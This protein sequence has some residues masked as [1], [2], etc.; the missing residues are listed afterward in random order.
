LT[1][2]GPDDFTRRLTTAATAVGADK[3]SLAATLAQSDLSDSEIHAV[4]G[5]TNALQIATARRLAG[6]SGARVV[7]LSAQEKNGQ[8]AIGDP[9]E[10]PS[11]HEDDSRNWFE[12]ATDAVAGA[13]SNTGNFLIHNPVSDKIFEGLDFLGNVAHLPFRLLS[14]A[15]DT[16]N[17]DEIDAQMKARGYDPNSTASYLAFMF[18]QGESQYHDLSHV[19]DVYGD[20]DVELA[21]QILDDPEQFYSDLQKRGDAE[22]LTKKINSKEFQ[23]VLDAVDRRHISPGRDLARLLTVEETKDN[24]GGF[25]TEGG[26]LFTALSGTLD[27]AYDWFTDPTLIIGKGARVARA[28][29]AVT[30]AT[31]ASRLRP[32]TWA[33]RGWD[34][35]RGGKQRAGLARGTDTLVDQSGVEALLRTDDSGRAVTTVG[36]GWQRYLEDNKAWRAARE[37]GDEAK[38][39]GIWAE[40]NARYGPMMSLWDEVGGARVIADAGEESGYRVERLTDSAL[41]TNGTPIEDLKTLRDHLVSTNGLVRIT[42]GWAAKKNLVMP[43]RLSMWAE[44]RAAAGTHRAKE[45]ERWANY[46]DHR[47]IPDDREQA[48]LDRYGDSEAARAGLAQARLMD[49]SALVSLRALRAKGERVYRRLA[50]QIPNVDRINLGDTS[51]PKVV[52]QLARTYMN[53]GDAARVASAYQAGTI[54][55]R[56]TILRGTIEQAFHASGLS[57]S[58]AGRNF[59]QRFLNDQD[60]VGN[61]LYGFGKTSAFETEGRG[62]IQAAL[63]PDQISRHVILPSFRE[64]NYLATKTAM[65]G[66]VGRRG[67]GHVRAIGQSEGMDALMG[68]IKMG[69]I[70]S[71]AGGLRNAIDEIA[72]FAAYGMLGQVAAARVAYTKA[73]EGLRQ[74]K[75]EAAR[76]RLDLIQ[77]WGRKEADDRISRKLGETGVSLDEANRAAEKARNAQ[78]ALDDV[79][80]KLHQRVTDAHTGRAEAYTYRYRALQELEDAKAAGLPEDQ[81]SV[82]RDRATYWSDE[83]SK[84]EATVKQHEKAYANRAVEIDKV[85]QTFADR[86]VLSVDDAEA[87]LRRAQK[88]YEDAQ[89]L[90]LAIS[91]R[92]PYAFRV[93]GDTINDKLIGAVLGKAMSVMGKDWAITGNRVKYAEELISP[94]LSRITRDGVYQS[95]HADTQLLEAS[96]HTAMD[97][98]RAGTMARR[99]SFRPNGWGEVEA[100]GGAG[101]DAWADNMRVR[102]QDTNSPAHAWVQTVHALA[103]DGMS[104]DEWKSVLEAA[105]NSVRGR[106]DD[107]ELRHFVDQAEAFHWYQGARVGDDETLKK[108]AKDEYADRVNADL[109][110]LLTARSGGLN[111]NVVKEIAE[112][113]VP[114]RSWLAQNVPTS[115]RP[116]HAIGQ[117]WAPYN[118]AHAPGQVPRGY[119]QFMSRAYN[120]VVTDQINAISRNPLMAALYMRARENTEGFVKG[121]VKDGWDESVADDLAQRIALRHAE[122]EAFKHIDNP[123]VSSQFSLIS[124]NYWAFVRAQEDWLK[125]W[126]RT[127]KDN[128]ELIR[129]AQLLIHG[130]EATGMLEADDQG[131]LHFIYPGSGMAMGLLNSFFGAMGQDNMASLPVTGELSSQLTFLNPSL[132]NPIGFSGTPLISLP[133]KAIGHFL[134]PS[135]ALFTQSMDKVINGDLGAGRK[136]Y[137]QL[138]P[139]TVNRIIGNVLD[140]GDNS[141][142]GQSVMMTLAHMKAAGQLD[143]PR[144]QTPEGQADLLHKLQVGTHNNMFLTTVLGFILP[145]AP[146]YDTTALANGDYQGNTPDVAAHLAGIRSLKDEA[147]QV[148]A[149]LPYEDALA[150]W[151]AN[152]PNE[153][154]YAPTGLGSRTTVGAEDASAPATIAAARYMEENPDFFSTDQ[155]YGGPG[156]LAAYF[157]P[158]GKAGTKNGEFS[159]V[160]YRAQLELGIRD[161]KDLSSYYNDLVLS[162]GLADYYA[163]KDAYEAKATAAG[164]SPALRAQ[165]DQQWAETRDALKAGNPLLAQKLASYAE[166]NAAIQSDVA[167]LHALVADTRPSTL[168]ALG[169]NRDGVAAM[170]AAR[171]AYV[172]ATEPLTN[173]RGSVATRQRDQA[174]TR[175]SAEIEQITAQYPGLA[176]LARGVFRLPS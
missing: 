78:S 148:F 101:L 30:G 16:E 125:R 173:R 90:S 144:L 91:H 165:L 93:V 163:A 79:E 128:P 41:G 139:S 58:E 60:E 80:N 11:E 43:G 26:G 89:R 131:Q 42:N 28:M 136:W 152:H 54:A 98:H 132:D 129:E 154:V 29:D 8:A 116:E 175:Y 171:D 96:D 52:D 120:K 110:Q 74:Q 56:R 21:T 118:P 71:A 145:A 83:I 66:W 111:L 81:L 109:A 36:K 155:G 18:N 87:Q 77:Q 53:R 50:T 7:G 10:D 112:G 104:R 39:A 40:A 84:A 172:A 46:N 33:A 158:Q 108:L 76:T 147:R 55:E 146:S 12:K 65:A 38:A 170:L 137:E 153:L 119:T 138:F 169:A 161:H 176:D 35:A 166:N 124:R 24:E 9:V 32:S 31:T 160:A 6:N 27:G 25:F 114:D 97:Y 142:F 23:G 141:H 107:E 134:G 4:G 149:S 122:A 62:T 127:I 22:Q 47:L 151:Q 140:T 95:H 5:F 106:V 126:G 150:W 99:Y 113:R 61:Q 168:K 167:R 45:T 2:P 174:K 130:G 67:L 17:N 19:R 57:R 3:P 70:T 85:K 133:W 94:E 105:R 1:S 20:D 48:I 100:D 156:G 117:L 162:R 69:W 88:A 49:R 143:D 34:I 15:V 92:L 75:R 115:A 64:M 86:G 102:F 44:K 103:K 59:I 72:N 135:N 68:T 63:Y 14:D 73:T 159:D 157:L 164:S 123:Y 37:D 82:I 13:L 51:S 121:L